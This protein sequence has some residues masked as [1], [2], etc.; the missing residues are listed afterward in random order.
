MSV[1]LFRWVVAPASPA[2]DDA[3]PGVHVTRVEGIST[4]EPRSR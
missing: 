2:T 1:F 3:R 4:M